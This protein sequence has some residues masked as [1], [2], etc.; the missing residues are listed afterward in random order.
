MLRIL[1]LLALLLSY[2]QQAVEDHLDEEWCLTMS[3]N[4]I[5]TYN[6]TKEKPHKTFIKFNGDKVLVHTPC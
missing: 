5:E 3:A 2:P 4:D 1:I 6:T